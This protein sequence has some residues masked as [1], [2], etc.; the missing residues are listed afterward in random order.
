MLFCLSL[1]ASP[2]VFAQVLQYT[3]KGAIDTSTLPPQPSMDWPFLKDLRKPM[4]TNHHWKARNAASDEANLSAG[5]TVVRSFAD[6][7]KLLETAYAN[8]EH[9]L[10]AGQVKCS[11]GGYKIETVKVDGYISEQFTLEVN[12]TGSRILASD[13]E[14]IR[15]GIFFLEDQM[16]TADGPFLKIGKFDRKPFVKR[17]I[18]R[19]F[20]APINRAGNHPGMSPDELIDDIDYY[21][22]NYLDRIAY[23]G[24]N[25]LWIAISGLNQRGKEAGI[26][27][28][29]KTSITPNAAPDGPKRLE[30]LRA[31]VARCKRYGIRV[32]IF[33]IE[34][35]VTIEKD[36]P[37]LK[38][39]PDCIGFAPRRRLC[40]SSE[41][42]QQYLYEAFYNLFKAIP[43]L[44]GLINISHGERYSSCLSS[45]S[46]TD[47]GTI[48]C[49]R[50]SKKEPW[51]IF[52]ECASAMEKG[53]HA[54]APNA[55]L[56][57][58]IYQPQPQA[59]T[60][61]TQA[62]IAAWSYE[63]PKHVP[64]GV[65][66]QS[67]FESGV[68]QKVFGKTLIGGDYWLPVPGPSDRFE[69]YAK[70]AR[71]NGTAVGAKIQTGGCHSIA[72][73]PVVPVP[74]LLYRKFDGMH[75][76]GV[77]Y[78]M[79][80]WYFGAVPSLMHKAAGRLS[81][82]PFPATEEEFLKELAAIEWHKQDREKVAAA[83]K[84][85]G[86][87]F[88]HYP[89][90]NLAQ[91]YGPMNWGIVWP[92]ILEPRVL[93]LSP[94]WRLGNF[95]V[96]AD[97]KPVY[98]PWAPSGDRVGESF[99]NLL[100]LDN[101]L[102]IHKTMKDGW[103]KGTEIF[104]SIEAAYKASPERTS[105]I[106]IVKA[107]SIHFKNSW[108]VYR[109]YDLREKAFRAQG[110]ARLPYLNEMKQIVQR[111]IDLSREMIGYCNRNSLLGFHSEAEGYKYYP[112]MIQWRI[113]QLEYLRDV[114]LPA[115]VAKVRKGELLYPEYTGATPV[116]PMINAT[117]VDSA[118]LTEVESGK[119]SP[120][121]T[122]D[123]QA[124]QF[125]SKGKNQI[126][127]ATG[128]D[129]S[130]LYILMEDATPNAK[131][132][133][134]PFLN[135]DFQLEKSRI[136]PC[137]HYQ[138]A[139]AGENRAKDVKAGKDAKT[140]HWLCVVRISFAELEYDGKL[141]PAR[142]DVLIQFRGGTARWRPYNRINYRLSLSPEDPFDLGWILFKK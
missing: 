52:A 51:Q 132:S 25:G 82:E 96:G 117:K 19:C 45:L 77:E 22:E 112:A 6:P 80:N 48:N 3:S 9:F 92:L 64:K 95:V 108:D 32:Y 85:L 113:K 134:N 61:D 111:E 4:W 72:T 75:R 34:P 130:S 39:Y 58:W 5:V 124:C 55:E 131:H 93:P 83:W 36:D 57:A 139:L 23:E 27:D 10:D 33:T 79:L 21:P 135:L 142:G 122:F 56:I 29:V 110:N 116:G 99:P 120:S 47:G 50:C 115:C 94:T 20:F 88:F 101:M 106:E 37:I 140:G 70:T 35:A 118:L 84:M 127:W 11:S 18:N 28:L 46:A 26:S 90:T 107:L 8:L 2:S 109:F 129:D 42:G 17:R 76:L 12:K 136:I 114:E 104:R 125:G 141:A 54:A 67:N 100:T 53:M 40:A 66:I 71:A 138:F 137:S 38:K 24:V 69:R 31:T 13:I 44:G 89:L 73:T 62:D 78:V 126:R 103:E 59:Q 65:I 97:G 105:D 121:R 14:G 49:P 81:F 63:I 60:K 98:S 119:L 123:W 43:D 102:S 68:T 74:S 30:K 91:Y 41:P 128:Y 87:A 15:R 1:V 133:E 86:D 16:L 7:E